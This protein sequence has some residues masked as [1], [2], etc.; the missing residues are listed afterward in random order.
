MASL[1]GWWPVPGTFHRIVVGTR[2]GAS[3]GTVSASR[4]NVPAEVRRG[5]AA[6]LVPGGEEDELEL[7]DDRAA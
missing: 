2:I 7:G 4:G 1:I 3:S 6:V 5:R